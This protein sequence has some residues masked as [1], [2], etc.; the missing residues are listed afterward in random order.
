MFVEKLL[1]VLVLCGWGCEAGASPLSPLQFEQQDSPAKGFS[2]R[3]NQIQAVLG[4]V[5]TLRFEVCLRGKWDGEATEI[6]T[7][8]HSC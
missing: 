3:E 2:Y 7:G 1:R 8:S 4:T 5:P 6:L